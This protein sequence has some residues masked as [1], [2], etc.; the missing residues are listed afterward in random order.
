MDILMKGTTEQLPVPDQPLVQDA[1]KPAIAS[2][3]NKDPYIKKPDIPLPTGM[4]APTRLEALGGA[5]LGGTLAGRFFQPYAN[6][7]SFD[8]PVYG[9]NGAEDRVK[10]EGAQGY[11][12][13]EEDADYL[14]NAVSPQ[15]FEVRMRQWHERQLRNQVMGV[16]PEVTFGAALLDADIL[17]GKVGAFAKVLG[18]SK[19]ESAAIGAGISTVA[20]AMPNVQTS[21]LDHVFDAVGGAVAGVMTNWK[22]TKADIDAAKKG[23]LKKDQEK[24]PVESIPENEHFDGIKPEFKSKAGDKPTFWNAVAGGVK[25]MQSLWD[26]ASTLGPKMKAL[27]D[28]TIGRPFDTESYVNAGTAAQRNFMLDTAVSLKHLEDVYTKLGLFHPENSMKAYSLEQRNLLIAERERV[29][30]AAQ[31]WLDRER[32]S[33]KL[34]TGDIPLPE[35]PIVRQVIEALHKTKHSE[36]MLRRAKEAGVEGAEEVFASRS[37]NPFVW[38]IDRVAATARR[39]NKYLTPEGRQR[40]KANA[41]KDRSRI[42]DDIDNNPGMQYV[43]RAFGTQIVRQFG[44]FSEAEA[45]AFGMQFLKTLAGDKTGN[46]ALKLRDW[47][48]NGL[49]MQEVANVLRAG[50]MVE[51]QVLANVERLFGTPNVKSIGD[52]TKSLRHRMDW[53][54]DEVFEAGDDVVGKETFTLAE[55]LE[56][57]LLKARERYSMEM[58][59]RIGLAHAGIKSGSEL[60]RVLDDAVDEAIE[61]GYS[62]NDA[63]AIADHFRE[64]LLGRPI[65]EDVPNFVKTLNA[66]ATSTVLGNS[67]IYNIGEFA[68]LAAKFGYT[69]TAKAFVKTIG[70]DTLKKMN[71]DEWKTLGDIITGRLVA[72]GRF[73]PVI[74]YLEDNFES[75]TGTVHELAQYASQSVRFLN[76]SE[77]IRRQQINMFAGLYQNALDKAMAAGRGSKEFRK[78][79]DDFGF[80]ADVLA[81]VEEAYRVYG[82]D[83]RLWTPETLDQLTSNAIANADMIVTA[84]R[85]GDRPRFMESTLGKVIFPFMGFAWAAHNKILRKHY[86]KDGVAGVAMIMA[87]QAPLAFLAASAANVSAGK[88]WDADFTNGVPKA[89]S[90]TGLFSIP[91]DFINR[92]RMGSGYVGFTPFNNAYKLA[93]GEGDL[94][95]TLKL[96]P[97]TGAFLGTNLTLGALKSE[98]N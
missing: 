60:Q 56:P 31:V 93:S 46:L 18:A 91:W 64:V 38:S 73:R 67:G 78:F 84:I 51:S 77:Y 30:I 41:N 92:G 82:R 40:L 20:G 42:W 89:M 21:A 47:E 37:Y 25:K 68:N 2:T 33:H 54:L 79:G 96:L 6:D 95:S 35:D 63:R 45:E 4:E 3:F 80:D 86:A 39:F 26:E 19:V 81:N 50:G 24:P 12:F 62:P 14:D 32:R 44:T 72:D 71:P 90:S 13:S 94:H 88:A 59:S 29:G 49:D 98:G 70:R 22:P 58:T 75:S 65:G 74:H 7:D 97:G 17:A 23:A 15:N 87:H 1:V 61:N 10:A 52:V 48:V 69:E 66:I 83:T 8:N 16:Y 85:K 27:A 53:N 55:F 34:G 76:G 43:A 36:N 9:Y 57:D 11:M 5:W 28:R